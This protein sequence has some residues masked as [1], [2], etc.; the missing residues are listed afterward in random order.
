[1]QDYSYK[2]KQDNYTFERIWQLKFG[3]TK[4]HHRC[5]T[6][7]FRGL[8]IGCLIMLSMLLKTCN[9]RNVVVKSN[10]VKKVV[11]VTDYV[12][13]SHIAKRP[14]HYLFMYKKWKKNIFVLFYIIFLYLFKKFICTEAP[15]SRH[16]HV[17]IK[18]PYWKLNTLEAW[19]RTNFKPTKSKKKIVPIDK[20]LNC[21]V[22]KPPPWLG[23][24]Y[25]KLIQT[26]SLIMTNIGARL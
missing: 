16:T 9:F 21:K 8:S 24:L 26:I 4:P 22:I 25:C 17:T 12:V 3:H 5:L 2:K 20:L 19:A 6:W 14:K 18:H 11:L 23:P 10:E 7:S 13:F 15:S 1:M